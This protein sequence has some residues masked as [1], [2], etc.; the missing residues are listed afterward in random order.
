V[1]H[2]PAWARGDVSTKLAAIAAINNANVRNVRFKIQFSARI[3]TTQ[4]IP[5]VVIIGG[6]VTPEPAIFP[7]GVMEL[8]MCCDG[9]RHIL[10]QLY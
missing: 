1:P 5:I 6:L 7:A 9:T 3:S 10:A 8:F 4:F 2:H